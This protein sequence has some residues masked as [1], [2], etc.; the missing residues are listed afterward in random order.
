MANPSEVSEQLARRDG[1]FLLWKRRTILLDGRVEVQLSPLKLQH[2]YGGNRFGDRSQTEEGRR[3][4]GSR[5]FQIRHAKSGGPHGFAVQ[6][7]SRANAGDAVGRHE[8][9]HRFFNCRALLGGKT[10]LLS[11]GASHLHE[12]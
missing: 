8:A 3:R 9:G 10:L 2:G 4:G 11:G 6:N 7:Y 1:P 5:V 12:R